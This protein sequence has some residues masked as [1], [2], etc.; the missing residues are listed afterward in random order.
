MTVPVIVLSGFLGSG[1]TTLLRRLL[2]EAE[3]RQLRPGVLMNELGRQDVDGALVG[4]G[5]AALEKLLD[6]CVC[7]S[8]KEEL[9]GSL[10]L[11]LQKSPD[12]V[13]I[14]LTGVANPEEIADAL[15]EPALLGRIRLKQIV[16]VLDAE[17]TLDYNSIFSADQQLVRTLRRQME[18]A[19][20]IIVNKVDLVR[21]DRLQKIEKAVR[22]Q[23]PHAAIA[24]AMDAA[25]EL[26]PLLADIE[27]SRD[28]REAALAPGSTAPAAS[29]FAVLKGAPQTLSARRGGRE[30]LHAGQANGEAQERASHGAPRSFS[31]VRTLT[32]PQPPNAALTRERTEKF[33][34]QW[35]DRL[36]RAKGYLMLEG[37]ASPALM[38]FAG[39]RVYWEASVYEGRPYVVFIGIDLDERR[40]AD[41]WSALL[42]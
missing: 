24:Y 23:N 31:R 13:L 9:A 6:G 41:E 30:D 36:L 39:Q 15:T 32:L 16:T 18:T 5:D 20:L 38:Q 17:H 28:S 19:D 40:L 3:R 1:K 33:L 37:S 4:R 22:K 25:V 26:S 2:L 34:R 7:C 35:K 8:K 11:L 21:Q 14:E 12:V 29:R 42:Q 10:L 27:R